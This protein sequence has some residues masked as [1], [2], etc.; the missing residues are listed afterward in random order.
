MFIDRKG[1]HFV[2][3][4]FENPAK[5]G[6]PISSGDI[7]H[8][9]KEDILT[10]KLLPGQMISEN[11]VAKLYR[12]SR[13][14]VKTAF[15]RLENEGFVDVIP[16][17]GTYVSKID[18][19]HISDISHMRYVLEMDMCKAAMRSPGLKT[20]IAD[21]EESLK[22]QEQMVASPD[23]QSYDFFHMDSN[24]HRLLFVHSN[25]EQIWSVIL[26]NQVFYTRLRLLDTKSKER[27]ENICV[28][29]RGILDALTKKDEAL[30]HDLVYRHLHY[31]VHLMTQSNIDEHRDF[32]INF[33]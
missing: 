8:M 9:L 16:Q 3:R 27:C 20:L 5:K 19:K 10:L 4:L 1:V 28:E 23:F 30:L 29:H 18:A 14:P 2:A 12:V 22:E 31:K 6:I 13:T 17:R 26:N 25:R 32:L 21:L 15:V 11:E 33:D 24:F 7:Y